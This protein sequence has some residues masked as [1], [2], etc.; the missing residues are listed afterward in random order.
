MLIVYAVVYSCNSCS[1]PLWKI[2][3]VITLALRVLFRK[4][5]KS[6]NLT[7]L[8][9]WLHSFPQWV[10]LKNI[11][12]WG[13]LLHFLKIILDSPLEVLLHNAISLFLTHHALCFP[14][15]FSFP[16]TLDP[17]YEMLCW[18]KLSSLS[19]FVLLLRPY[20]E[21]ISNNLR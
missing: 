7:S 18:P 3:S 15:E 12:V 13:L 5:I 8:S 11:W 21:S 2:L 17:S 20:I 9:N 19:H 16:I 1:W 14:L 10:N 4:A 6:R